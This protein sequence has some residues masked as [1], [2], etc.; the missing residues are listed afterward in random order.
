MEA[1]DDDMEIPE[2]TKSKSSFGG[3]SFMIFLMLVVL[4]LYLIVS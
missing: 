3:C 4:I 1:I 2:Y